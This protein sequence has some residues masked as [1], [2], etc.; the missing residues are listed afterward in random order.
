MQLSQSA[1][2]WMRQRFRQ[3]I[4]RNE[5]S[6]PDCDLRL[7]IAMANSV[8]GSSEIIATL[9]AIQWIGGGLEAKTTAC[10]DFKLTSASNS[11]C[12]VA[13]DCENA[14]ERGNWLRAGR[15]PTSDLQAMR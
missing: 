15:S 14:Q 10:Q 12:E 7:P 5:K 13:T 9:L 4:R 1:I 8:V 11:N 3:S 6:M 2:K